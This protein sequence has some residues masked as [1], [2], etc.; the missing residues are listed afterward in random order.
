[1]KKL[2]KSELQADDK[3]KIDEEFKN[4]EQEVLNQQLLFSGLHFY[5]ST[6]VPR[7]SL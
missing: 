5:L 2:P 7:E 4:V 3:Y 6:E 1:M